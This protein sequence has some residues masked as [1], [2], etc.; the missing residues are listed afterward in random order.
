MRQV[1]YQHCRKSPVLGLL[2]LPGKKFTAM[3]ISCLRHTCLI[4]WL[5]PRSKKRN[6]IILEF[7]WH[8]FLRERLRVRR[9]H[10]SGR[11]EP[12][13]DEP[14]LGQAR[15]SLF[16]LGRAQG[17]Q[18]DLRPEH[19]D[20]PEGGAHEDSRHRWEWMSC[21]WAFLLIDHAIDWC[22]KTFRMDVS[23]VAT[24]RHSPKLEDGRGE[25]GSGNRPVLL[26][27]RPVPSPPLSRRRQSQCRE[28]GNHV[29]IIWNAI[30]ITRVFHRLKRSPS[31]VHAG[32]T[33]NGNVPPSCSGGK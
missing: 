14:P 20:C 33:C 29:E 18:S 2:L 25:T 17:D 3:F 19:Q 32:F 11:D 21:K 4:I 12:H 24:H 23:N 7:A 31:V 26:H 6:C 5:C 13:R 27:L 1:P 16:P 28:Q 15:P 8:R 10:S 22:L 9:P 30:K